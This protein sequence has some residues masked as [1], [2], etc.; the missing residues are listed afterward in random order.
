MTLFNNTVIL[1]LMNILMS[2]SVTAFRQ[3]YCYRRPVSLISFVLFIVLATFAVIS[4]PRTIYA[5]PNSPSIQLSAA[6]SLPQS[7]G[8]KLKKSWPWYVT[9]GSGLVAA[10]ALILLLLSGIGFITGTTFRFLE[11]LSAWLTH[12]ALGIAFAIS[13][14]IHVLVLLFDKHQRF[15]IIDILIPFVSDFK[16]V[17]FGG[18]KLGSL[19]LALGILAL[20][21][22]IA[23][24]ATSLLWIDKKPFIWRLVHYLSY[25]IMTAVYVHALYLGTDIKNGVFRILWYGLGILLVVALA[26]RA[27]RIGTTP[28]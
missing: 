3:L 9:R 21:G 7:A 2:L 23:V 6:T 10:T 25:G 13:V 27:W 19:Y 16:P 4:T 20:Y 5:T 24:V 17:E 11:P 18:I 8:Q 15:S 1:K 12:R 14:A 26:F 28:K 22:T